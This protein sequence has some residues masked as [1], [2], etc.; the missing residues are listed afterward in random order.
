LRIVQQMRKKCRSPFGASALRRLAQA[1]LFDSRFDCLLRP[2][3][4]QQIRLLRS[5]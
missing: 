4:A 1:R 5:G 3:A 2:K